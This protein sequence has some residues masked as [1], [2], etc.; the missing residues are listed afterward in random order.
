MIPR[1]RVL[2]GVYTLVK[3]TGLKL[4]IIAP[5]QSSSTGIGTITIR[6]LEYITGVHKRRFLLTSCWFILAIHTAV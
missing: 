1:S 6:D 3:D 5:E 2:R 4:G